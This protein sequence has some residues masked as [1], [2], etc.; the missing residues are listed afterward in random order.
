MTTD[1]TPISCVYAAPCSP[2][3]GENVSG[4]HP[5]GFRASY[6]LL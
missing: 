4:P 1:Q 2:F 5:E 6:G 3:E